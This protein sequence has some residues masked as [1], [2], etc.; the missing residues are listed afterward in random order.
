MN[1][2]RLCLIV[3]VAAV[4]VAGLTTDTIETTSSFVVSSVKV[5]GNHHLS[6]RQIKDMLR[7][8]K[9]NRYEGYLFN[10]LLER[11]IQAV[12]ETYAAEGFAATSV[13]WT[14]RDVSAGKRGLFI[15][16]DEGPRTRIAE[17]ILEGVSPAHYLA[18]RENLGVDVGSPLSASVL[19]KARGKI[20]NYYANRGYVK[21]TARAEIDAEAGK[22]KFVVAEGDIYHVGEIFVA[23]NVRT[24]AKIITRELDY[25]LKPD[26]LYRGSKIDEGRENIYRTGLYRDLKVEAVDSKRSPSLVD[27]VVVVREDKFKWYKL[28]PGYESPDRAA[29]T[30]GWGHNNVF[31]NNQRLA[32]EVSAAHG[33]V[34]RESVLGADVTYTEPWLFGYRYKGSLTFFAERN[35]LRGIRTWEAGVE[36]RVTREVTERLDVTGA[37]KVRRAG[38]DVTAVTGGRE[39]IIPFNGSSGR[40]AEEE[41]NLNIASVT[42]ATTYDRRDDIFNPL[43]GVYLY[44]AEETAGIF[45]RTDFWRVKVDGRAYNRVGPAAT[46]AVCFRGGYAKPYGAT[47]EIPYTERF[48]A[49]GAYS[50]RGYGERMV[51]PKDRDTPL[52]GSVMMTANLELRFQIP[53]FGE[54]RLPGVGLN[55]G[56]FWGGF[57]MDAGNVWATWQDFKKGRVFYGAGAGLRYNTPVGP[58]RLDV[59][60]PILEPEGQGRGHFYVAFGHIF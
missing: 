31:D 4:P 38:V 37:L 19:E 51:G 41:G 22:V 28:E 32:A 59:A 45:G 11:G 43:G 30:V 40:L 48:F 27:L 50:V 14:F 56:N 17:L 1:C 6:D 5:E 52:G 15:R 55:L 57:F 23:G 12:K 42:A 26:R 2:A 34:T 39:V 47:Q 49:G 33:F 35:L 60:Q 18:V 16:I 20:L 13:R 44:G 21:A 25:K 58:L 53:F 9:G 24:R 7:L 29:L 54:R 10:F 8:E 36:P 46:A 3:T